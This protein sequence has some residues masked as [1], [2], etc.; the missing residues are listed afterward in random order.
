VVTIPWNT[1]GA[2]LGNHNLEASHDF[3]DTI[4]G[5]NLGATVVTVN[6]PSGSTVTLSF[7]EGVDGYAGTVD[8][9]LY[10]SSASSPQGGLDE[11]ER[12]AGSGKDQIALFRFDNIFGPGRT[13]FPPE[14]L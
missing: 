2:T 3:V 14:R 1:T 4:P 6:P 8:T 13:R 7:Q 12:D 9:Y 11:V 5:N 10:E